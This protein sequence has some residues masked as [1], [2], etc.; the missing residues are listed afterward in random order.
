[1]E[2]DRKQ[3]KEIIVMVEQQERVGVVEE[4]DHKVGCKE[5]LVY[6]KEELTYNYYCIE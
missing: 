3:V 6:W 5:V 2:E 1:M 4:E